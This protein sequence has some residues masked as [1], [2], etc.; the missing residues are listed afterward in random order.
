MAIT[1]NTDVRA[2]LAEIT[3]DPSYG[4]VSTVS[5]LHPMQLAIILFAVG[6]F[7]FAVYGYMTG[8]FGLPVAWLL[9]I[10]ACYGAFTTLHDSCHKALSSNK[11]VN[12]FLGTIVGQLVLPGVTARL[13][14]GLHMDHH[15]YVGDPVH[16]PDHGLVHLPKSMGLFYLFFVDLHW[17]KWYFTVGRHK[18]PTHLRY[19]IWLLAIIFI[20]IHVIGLLSPWW[21]EFLMLYIIPQRLASFITAYCFAHIQ[22]PHDTSWE[23][24]PFRATVKIT[25]NPLKRFLFL[26]QAD[27]AMHHFAPHVPWYKYHRVWDLADGLLTKKGIPERGAFT[28]PV[29]DPEEPKADGA[30]TNIEENLAFEVYCA[31][32]DMTV[33][34][35][36]EDTLLE[37]LI[38]AGLNPDYACMQGTCGSC[39][40]EVIAGDVDHRDAFLDEDD[41]AS[42]QMM[43]LCV[44]RAKGKRL[45]LDI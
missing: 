30:E 14:R 11:F 1:Q 26:G 41:K 19:S 13:Y 36:A 23:E 8:L 9:I 4:E 32:S 45:E 44:S 18:W 25:G 22:H 15:R 37:V 3:K 29:V 40:T 35:G 20:A 2:V 7:S 28:P 31:A 21:Y 33:E 12:D 42:N 10:P 34:V 6:S 17:H 39:V 43:C 38:E 5:L 24:N 16:D 27:H